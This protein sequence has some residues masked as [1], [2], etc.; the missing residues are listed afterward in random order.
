MQQLGREPAGCQRA[1]TVALRENI[2]CADQ[3]AQSF[4]I[5]GSAQIELGRELAVPAIRLLIAHMGQMRRGDFEHL[6][7]MFGK[8][9]AADRAGEQACQIENAN[10]GQGSF[11]RRQRLRWAV[12]D[13]DNLHDRERRNGLSLRMSGPL[14][15]GPHHGARAVR[16][17][18]GL[19]KSR[20]FHPASA[21]VTATRFPSQPRTLSAAAKWFGKA[22]WI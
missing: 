22:E 9:P 3:L 11:A 10:A 20:A 6:R 18:Q 12:P 13:A 17:D 15:A 8:S 1:G 4:D 21:L 14:G 7:A 16:G 19:F 2:R 5:A